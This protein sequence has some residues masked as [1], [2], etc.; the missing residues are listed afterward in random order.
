LRARRNDRARAAW[1]YA[2]HMID[3]RAP[4]NSHAQYSFYF[5]NTPSMKAEEHDP[6]FEALLEFI[7]RTRGFDFTGYK[8]TSLKRLINKRL[9]ETRC[10]HFEQYTEY[11]LNNPD[12]YTRVFNTILINVTS[13]FRNRASWDV[14]QNSLLPQLLSVKPATE[15]VRVWTAACA[16]GEE[17]YTTAMVL[18][19]VMGIDAFV[20]RVKIYGTD[21]DEEALVHARQGT[22]T[23]RDLEMVPP[24]YVEK[25]FEPQS[26]RFAFQPDLRRTMIFGRH[27]LVTD[28]SISKLDLLVCRNALMY[29]K[30]ELQNRIF[31][32]FHFGLNSPGY[33]FLGKAE[34]LLS[35]TELFRA[36]DIRN[37]IFEKIPQPDSRKHM[38]L[39]ARN[40]RPGR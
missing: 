24:E 31:M 29:F 8:R 1:H 7:K 19:E 27:N 12:E 25:Y 5:A 13:F 16:S 14:L 30:A 36:V 15:P 22:Y 35:G 18:A 4:R 34:M 39:L 9:A 40:Y 21:W 3:Q 32:R 17:T 2:T 37:R 20:E 26:G 33:L 38:L 10:D 11:L 23:A 6:S 28:A